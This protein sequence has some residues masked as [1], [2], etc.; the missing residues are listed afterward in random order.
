MTLPLSMQTLAALARVPRAEWDADRH[1]RLDTYLEIAAESG[2][3]TNPADTMHIA[4][5]LL[6][7]HPP[8]TT[9]SETTRL[10]YGLAATACAPPP[11]PSAARDAAR[12]LRR[13]RG[14]PRSAPV[15]FSGFAAMFLTPEEAAALADGRDGGEAGGDDVD[16]AARRARSVFTMADAD[17]VSAMMAA[18]HVVHSTLVVI[19]PGFSEPG[20][21]LAALEAVRAVVSVLP[22]EFAARLLPGTAG[23]LMKF[24]ALCR[25]ERSG[26]VV[27]AI[28]ALLAVM[29]RAFAGTRRRTEANGTTGGF[30]GLVLQLQETSKAAVESAPKVASKGG[31]DVKEEMRAGKIG[32]DRTTAW[33]EESGDKIS[34]ALPTLLAAS[35]GVFAHDNLWVRYALVGGCARLCM[36]ELALSEAVCRRFLERLV[37]SRS[38]EIPDIAD[39]AR[40]ELGL[41]AKEGVVGFR[42]LKDGLVSCILEMRGG[43]GEKMPQHGGV[44]PRIEELDGTKNRGHLACLDGYVQTLNEHPTALLRST[45]RECT[46]QPPGSAVINAVSYCRVGDVVATLITS[47]TLGSGS[48]ESGNEPE[49]LD[50]AAATLPIERVRAIRIARTL[51]NSGALGLL[52]GPLL[53]VGMPSLSSGV[54]GNEGDGE[55]ESEQ[56]MKERWA[57]L[58]AL[59]WIVVGSLSRSTGGADDFVNGC[60]IELLRALS[61]FRSTKHSYGLSGPAIVNRSIAALH[62]GCLAAIRNVFSVLRSQ[63]TRVPRKFALEVILG[64][65]VDMAVGEGAVREQ[66]VATAELIA[67]VYGN[68]TWRGW[69]HSHLNFVVGR[70]LNDV[71]RHWA[72]PVIKVLVGS[73]NDELCVAATSLVGD[74]LSAECDGLAAA[75]NH[76]AIGTLS[77]VHGILATAVVAATPGSSAEKEAGSCAVGD[78]NAREEKD[79]EAVLEIVLRLEKDL[80]YFATEAISA[81]VEENFGPA[82][83]VQEETQEESELCPAVNDTLGDFKLVDPFAL[84]ASKALDGCK[85]LFVGRPHLVT[86][87]A[88]RCASVAVEVLRND[89]TQLLP[90]VATI[91]PLLPGHFDSQRS[92]TGGRRISPGVVFRRKMLMRRRRGVSA[93]VAR[94]I[95]T[96]YAVNDMS[97]SLQ[98]MTDAAELL[99]TLARCAGSFVRERFVRLIFPALEPLLEVASVHSILAAAASSKSG[100][101]LDP[102]DEIPMPC[103]AA[104]NAADAAIAAVATVAAEVPI[105]LIPFQAR[106]TR[107]LAPFLAEMPPQCGNKGAHRV[108]AERWAKRHASA[109]QFMQALAAFAPDE[110]WFEL[111]QL[112]AS[113][114]AMAG[115]PH[116]SLH[117]VEF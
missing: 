75:S 76:R 7:A 22:P 68:T 106:M 9:P 85:D 105:A 87:A 103:H 112:D 17:G 96:V 70:V 51:G 34:A 32:I 94:A 38:D 47:F 71:G 40:D 60:V 97:A 116:P 45:E 79:D 26:V 41:L 8:T 81:D 44:R 62:A 42:K 90:H 2:A 102:A 49:N 104:E 93:D 86:A 55:E 58:S 12:L 95:E 43:D 54:G 63:L 57:A 19:K 84:L 73:S 36:P 39:A 50:G 18:A 111:M 30:S 99:A 29:E 1:R 3:A 64:L 46:G 80:L 72:G 53:E 98:V 69:A 88:L 15:E 13:S 56:K 37:A 89:E 52:H 117:D 35:E 100:C 27:A 11:Q 21:V 31:A 5:T 28:R 20:V 61:F 33:V 74:T 101:N 113:R 4:S 23:T 109:V 24:L 59:E 25:L 91:L 108:G 82:R 16:A 48:A 77:A 114:N 83:P 66:A 10:I 65:L 107:L 115:K 14:R 92:S 67:K 78:P 110:T 6:A